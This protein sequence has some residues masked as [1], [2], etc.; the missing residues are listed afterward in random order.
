MLPWD[1]DYS[2]V[3]NDISASP[4]CFCEVE[5]CLINIY[6]FM[7]DFLSIHLQNSLKYI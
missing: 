1:I 7:Q 3:A 2:P 6:E 4:S 5:P